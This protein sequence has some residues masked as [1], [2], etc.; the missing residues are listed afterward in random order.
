MNLAAYCDFSDTNHIE[1]VLKLLRQISA[2]ESM[3]F[4]NCMTSEVQH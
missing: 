2:S 3:L 1:T 4:A